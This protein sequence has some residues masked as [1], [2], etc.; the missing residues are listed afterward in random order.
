MKKL[1]SILLAGLMVVSLAACSDNT[2]DETDLDA[3]RQEEI[4]VDNYTNEKG[5][6]FYFDSLDSETVTITGYKGGDVPHAVEIPSEM[7]G[8]TV[9][10]IGE[11]AFYGLS[12]ITE[13]TIPDTVKAIRS[14]A[15]SYCTQLKS[16]TIPAGVEEIE[17]GAF[18]RCSGIKTITFAAGSA[19]TELPYAAF[20]ECTSLESLTIPANIKTVGQGAF[21]GCASLKTI[22]IEE[23]VETLAVQA[24]QDCTELEAL[25]LPASLLAISNYNFTGCDGLYVEGVTLPADASSAAVK[26]IDA[27]ELPNKPAPEETPAA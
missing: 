3:Y 23:G 15:F 14:L 22:V 13:V 11:S 8:K 18:A 4:V 20:K 5:Q 1:F 17:A 6:I 27:L 7:H 12:N 21:Q 26:Y 25:T 10:E 9:A 2:E 19:L 24:F 16:I